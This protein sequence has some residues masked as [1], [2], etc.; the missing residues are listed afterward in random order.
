L[1]ATVTMGF[2]LWFRS[3]IGFVRGIWA[4]LDEHPLNRYFVSR[5]LLI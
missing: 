3:V 1:F 4:Y 2:Y 5:C